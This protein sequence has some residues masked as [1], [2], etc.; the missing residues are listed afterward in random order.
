MQN[1]F[2]L[3][4]VE[5]CA[6]NDSNDLAHPEDIVTIESICHR[7][8]LYRSTHKTKCSEYGR[9]QWP[10]KFVNNERGVYL[11]DRS[12][13]VPCQRNKINCHIRHGYLRKPDQWCPTCIVKLPTDSAVLP[14]VVAKSKTPGSDEVEIVEGMTQSDVLQK[15][16]RTSTGATESEPVAA[17]HQA[18]G[19]VIA[20]AMAENDMAKDVAP[21]NTDA[22]PT[23]PKGKPE[24]KWVEIV[25]SS[26]SEVTMDRKGKGKAVALP[27]ETDQR[28]R[29]R[30][31]SRDVS[32]NR[33][34]IQGNHSSTNT[35]PMATASDQRKPWYE[36]Q[37]RTSTAATTVKRQKSQ[38]MFREHQATA[39]PES[40]GDIGMALEADIRAAMTLEVKTD[41]ESLLTVIQDNIN[42]LQTQVADIRTQNAEMAELIQNMNPRLTAQDT[43]I[44]AMEKMRA[45][46]E[47][48]QEEVKALHAESQTRES[49]IRNTDAMLTAQ[50]NCTAVLMDAYES[51]CQRVVPN[52][53][54]PHFNN[55]TFFPPAGHTATYSQ[56][57]SAGQA[58]AMERLYFNLTPVPSMITGNSVPNIA[59]RARP[60]GSQTNRPSGKLASGRSPA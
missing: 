15:R 7:T 35:L 27:V 9:Q 14:S 4:V 33:P 51:L 22:M 48:L 38:G 56:G 52:Q 42:N 55:A 57:M 32:S 24:S 21:G 23:R 60:S 53:T 54:V 30:K 46:I 29:G 8:S 37:K 41:S 11:S 58:Q 2:V 44:R 16:K 50:G 43:D 13:F 26:G 20:P 19:N 45:E 34:P 59:T 3:R 18:T 40:V 6:A 39:T 12:S 49:Q 25:I 10:S 17:S 36:I 31:K 5:G 47:I 1:M 28:D